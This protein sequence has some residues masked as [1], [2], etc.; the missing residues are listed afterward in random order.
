[1]FKRRIFIAYWALAISLLP[2]IA[3]AYIDPATTTYII[4]IITAIVITLGVTLG[5]LLYRIRMIAM[6]AK[7]HFLRLRVRASSAKNAAN[8]AVA[9][10]EAGSGQAAAEDDPPEYAIPVRE[11]FPAVVSAGEYVAE[12]APAAPLAREQDGKWKRLVRD[13][14]RFVRRALSILPLSFALSFSFIVFSCLDLYIANYSE[15][16]FTFSEAAPLILETGAIAFLIITVVLMIFKGVLLDIL[17][18][19]AFAALIAGYLQST[20]LNKGLNQLTGEAMDWGAHTG[21]MLVNVGIWIG[22][23]AVILALRYFS[24]TTWRRLCVILPLVII[25]IQGVALISESS[26]VNHGVAGVGQPKLRSENLALTYEGIYD[27][28]AKKNTIVFLLDKLDSQYIRDVKTSDPKFFDKLDGFTEFTNNITHYSSTFPSVINTL[29]GEMYYY[30]Y[31]ANTYSEKAYGNSSFFRDLKTKNYDLRLYLLKGYGYAD[32]SDFGVEIDN[33]NSVRYKF[34][35][36]VALKKLLKLSAYRTAPV[37]MKPSFEMMPAEMAA[38]VEIVRD[39]YGEYSDDDVNFYNGLV[40]DKLTVTGENSFIF[41]HMTGPHEPFT[42]NENMERVDRSSAVEQTKGSFNIVYEY[43]DQLKALGLYENTTI[44]IT[45]DH[46]SNNGWKIDHPYVTGLFVKPAGTESGP[47]KS[48]NAPVAPE[49][50]RATAIAAAG[51]DTGGY[52]PTYFNAP[53]TG[54]EVRT[55]VQLR[56]PHNK[57]PLEEYDVVGDANDLTNWHKLREFY[58]KNTT[59]M[60]KAASGP[61]SPLPSASSG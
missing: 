45:G 40:K 54:N 6:K 25:V 55:Y 48:S 10:A 24:R 41:Y 11:S 31:A 61:G 38:T 32:V 2:C 29:T 17:M 23:L 12:E 52:G 57:I 21:Q 8:T 46:A 39:D 26:T 15:M 49:N 59:S 42:M 47:L 43:I 3:Y 27:V 35:S 20:F 33:V 56:D 4:Q 58:S 44:I 5:V 1:M 14:R 19:V 51:L 9:G 60:F 22:V 28:G 18:S 34:K 53:N 36:K 37:A 30:D 7:A 16:P 50:L 13:D